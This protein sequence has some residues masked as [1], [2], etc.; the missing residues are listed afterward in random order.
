MRPSFVSFMAVL[1]VSSPL[2][3]GDKVAVSRTD[4]SRLIAHQPGADVDYKPGVDVRG[5]KVAP[6][7]LAGSQPDIRL[8]DQIVIDIGFDLSKR[9]GIPDT[10][11]GPNAN[12]YAGTGSVGKVTVDPRTG[13]ASFNGQSLTSPEQEALAEA[14]RRQA[15]K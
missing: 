8:P 15:G 14:C 4:C 11:A 1:L 2:S 13:K 5:R 12:L 9:F 10:Q 3:A 7:D 6:A